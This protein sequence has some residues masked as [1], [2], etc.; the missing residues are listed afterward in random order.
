[1]L[2]GN[3]DADSRRRRNFLSLPAIQ[4]AHRLGRHNSG[5]WLSKLRAAEIRRRVTDFRLAGDRQVM[6]R[7]RAR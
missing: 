3:D 5:D 7:I 2:H 6:R 4:V 1:M